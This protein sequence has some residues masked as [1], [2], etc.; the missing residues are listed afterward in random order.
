VPTLLI[1]GASARAA[2]YSA[3]RAGFSPATIDLFADRD[4]SFIANSRRIPRASYPDGLVE[5]A[6]ESSAAPWIY[7]GALENRPDLIDRLQADRTLWG[8]GAE[9]LRDVRSPIA[10]A[11]ALRSAGLNAPEVR[12]ERPTAQRDGSWLRKPLASV[13]GYGVVK[14]GTTTT[15]SARPSY[16]QRFIDGESLSAVFIGTRQGASLAGVTKQLVG[17][18]SAPFAYRGSIAPWPVSN[19]ATSRIADI[20]DVLARRFGLVGL[21]GVDLILKD[22]EPW[23]VEVNPRYTASVEVIELSTGRALLRNHQEACE[24]TMLSIDRPTPASAPRFVAKE[25]LFAEGDGVFD[26][27]EGDVP[28]PGPFV[29]PTI[30]DVPARGT[31]FLPGEPILTV[32][33]EA[34]SR[35]ECLGKLAETRA[36]YAQRTA[37]SQR[38]NKPV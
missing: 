19:H 20:G 2:A 8:N 32:F 6:A 12:L 26:V 23:S 5:A 29:V 4:L 10:L 14:F 18:A 37:S 36:S 16:Y 13:G 21:F 1:L 28:V 25:I 24:G 17:R 9:T 15:L 7:T 3:R 30:A 11:E 31:R 27:P 34:A 38:G 33:A 22:D 35:S